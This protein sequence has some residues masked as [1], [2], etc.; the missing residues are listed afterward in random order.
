LACEVDDLDQRAKKRLNIRWQL[1]R[2]D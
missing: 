2:R 1:S